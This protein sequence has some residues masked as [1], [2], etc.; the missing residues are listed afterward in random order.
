MTLEGKGICSGKHAIAD[1]LIEHQEFKLLELNNKHYPRITDDPEDDL[2]L[3]ASELSNKRNSEFTFDSV[4][5]LL[6]FATKRWKE[7][8]VTTDILDTATIE[9]FLQRPFFLLVSVDA[10]VSLRWKRFTDRCRRR[11]LDPPPLER[12]VIWNDRHL[13]DKDI[14]RAYLTDRAQV[15]LF[16]SCSSLEEL[17]VALEALN[18]ADERR[19]RPNWDLYF[20]Q[21][22]SLAAQ[23]S[24]CMKRRAR[25][26]TVEKEE[27]LAYR[28]VFAFMRKRT[29]CWK[30]AESVYAKA[31]YS[32]AIRN[33]R[34]LVNA[35]NK[36]GF[37]VEWIKS[38]AD[39][40]NA[41]KLMVPG[42]GHF[43]HCLSQLSEGGFLEPIR[44][45][46][47]L[48][49]PFMGICVGLQA[50]FE[51]SEEDP[52]TPGLGLIPQRMQKFNADTKSVPHI[53]WNSAMNTTSERQT[54]YGLNPN[55]KY[56]YVHSFA[57]LYKAGVLENDGW[58]V[59][60]ATYGEEEFIGA[61]AR[62]N[63]F[64]TQFHP[65]KSGQAG[66][67]T[68]RAFLNG[69]KFQPLGTEG[70]EARKREDG[71]TRR[72]IAC[73]D[74]RTN[75]AGDLVVTK[76]DQYDV[77]EKAGV[78]AGGQVRNLGKPVDMAKRYYE[79]GADE[80]TF[81]NITS[82]RNC[83]LV[84]T[85]MLEVLRRT[86]ETVFVPLTIGG[87]IKDT[88]DPDGTH[89]SALD[90]ATMYFKSGA[91]K[92]SIGSDAVIAAEEYYRRGEKLTGKTAIET[93]SKA[94]GNQAVVVSVDPKRVYVTSPDDTEHHTIKT[95]YPN[96]SGQSYCWYQCTIKGGR[97]SRDIDVRQ[98]VKAV[99]A[100]G[101]GEIL[102]NCIDKDGSNS[103]FDLE[104][105]NDVKAASKIPVIASSGAGV[106]K[107]FED[108]FRY[109]TTDA[110]LGAGMFHRGEFTVGQ[111]KEHLRNE[112]FLVRNFESDE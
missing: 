48:G 83:P 36:V 30:Q 92:V 77:R 4:E 16:N 89:I 78:G 21:L 110:A 103:G 84:D 23:R 59:A 15:R 38:P 68:L 76:G 87:G 43:G 32:I 51:G 26:A 62:E 106:P 12:F 34:S 25:D 74:V 40:Q 10:P 11:Q 111:V 88:I 61:I 81:L 64:A 108:V 56:Y 80:V 8:W 41:D 98:L 93:I 35:I 71:L 73:L 69:D 55:S 6:D 9:R 2:R 66:L 3:Q 104:L 50:L 85:P 31:Q 33:V 70:L 5:S 107:H 101:A 52:D 54:F 7:R 63:I 109:T 20:M 14:G 42:V 49:K 28:H 37:D 24:N 75:D 46:I 97:E 86:S 105:I 1:Y 19:L 102:L 47:E 57:A 95:K 100:M 18:L 53:G 60:T 27:V 17:H 67:R 13:Y 72:I 99:E 79:Q 90:V 29:L 22:A 39:I 96:A 94:Y 82:F 44:Q 58:S 65:E 112:G 45:H 91:D